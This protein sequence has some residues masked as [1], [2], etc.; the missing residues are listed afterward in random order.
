MITCSFYFCLGISSAVQESIFDCSKISNV[1]FICFQNGF[2][3]SFPANELLLSGFA[4]LFLKLPANKTRGFAQHVKSAIK[5]SQNTN[6]SS[7]AREII[8]TTIS[9]SCLC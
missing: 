6:M 3:R 4:R 2:P 9:A 7:S 1:L 8:A 5:S